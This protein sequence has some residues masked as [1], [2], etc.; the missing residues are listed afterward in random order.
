MSCQ[1]PSLSSQ[2][3]SLSPTTPTTSVCFKKI[4]NFLDTGIPQDK[5]KKQHVC[6][7]WTWMHDAVHHFHPFSRC[8]E[9]P[10]TEFEGLGCP[11]RRVG[12][13][14]QT[15]GVCQTLEI[16]ILL[17]PNL[18]I[19]HCFL[20][21]SPSEK[22]GTS[23]V[24]IILPNL[25]ISHTFP[26]WHRS[27]ELPP[28]QRCRTTPPGPGRCAAFCPAPA[29]TGAKRWVAPIALVGFCGGFP[30]RC[31]IFSE[32]NSQSEGNHGDLDQCYCLETSILAWVQR[33][34]FGEKHALSTGGFLENPLTHRL[35]TA[36][37]FCFN[38]FPEANIRVASCRISCCL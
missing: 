12:T 6:V 9:N 17:D 30:R 33:F 15:K 34:F 4:G 32:R 8:Y 36:P 5:R 26:T 21:S 13:S 27:A 29:S 38:V 16:W 2:I 31:W 37:Q 24:W 18:E 7:R 3:I 25:N 11:K 28:P 1:I 20:V 23:S 35:F 14:F 19:T 10:E 22:Y